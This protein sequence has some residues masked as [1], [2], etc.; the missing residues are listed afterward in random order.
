MNVQQVNEQ[1]KAKDFKQFNPCFT[2][3]RHGNDKIFI[4]LGHEEM[5]KIQPMKAVFVLDCELVMSVTD[6]EQLANNIMGHVQQLKTT[7]VTE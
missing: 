4:T 1:I 3:G 7:V 2:F 5:E 6:A